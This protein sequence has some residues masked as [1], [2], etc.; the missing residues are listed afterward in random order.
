MVIYWLGV[1]L[2]LSG[3]VS[4]IPAP[5]GVRP[6]RIQQLGSGREGPVIGADCWGVSGPRAG[7]VPCQ[8]LDQEDHAVSAGS[9]PLPAGTLE[10]NSIS[11]RQVTPRACRPMWRVEVEWGPDR[12]GGGAPRLN[13]R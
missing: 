1:V 5:G 10:S 11:P 2:V 3:S 4:G 6:Q 12:S 9:R 7:A 13:K 8:R